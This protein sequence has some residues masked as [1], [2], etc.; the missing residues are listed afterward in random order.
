[1]IDIA[2][3]FYFTQ[4]I[5]EQKEPLNEKIQKEYNLRKKDDSNRGKK[6]N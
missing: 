4:L 6:M 2:A 5:E 1:L 3:Y